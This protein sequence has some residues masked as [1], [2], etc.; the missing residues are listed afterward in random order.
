MTVSQ[1]SIAQASRKTRLLWALIAL[2]CVVTYVASIPV[3]LTRL[4][5]LCMVSI[6]PTDQLTPGEYSMLALESISLSTYA[7][8]NLVGTGVFSV[9][10]IVVG[11][12]IALRLPGERM[13]LYTSTT[14]LVFGVFATEQVDGLGWLSFPLEMWVDVGSSAAWV[15]F[16]VLLFVFPDGH[17]YPGWTRWLAVAWVLTQVPYFVGQ[18]FPAAVI[19][20]VGNWP[21]WA[22]LP[23][24]T[25]LFGAGVASQITRY[26]HSSVLQRQQTKWVMLGLA[27]AAAGVIVLS[28]LPTVL[29]IAWFE[30]GSP[31]KMVLDALVTFCLLPLPVS[32]AA[33]ILRRRLWDVD[34]YIN[35]ALVY[36]I[37]TAIIGLAYMI[38]VIVFQKMLAVLVGGEG[39]TLSTALTTLLVVALFFPLRRRLQ[40]W[41]DRRFYRRRYDAEQAVNALGAALRTEVDP[42]ALSEQVLKAVDRAMLPDSLSLWLRPQAVPVRGESQP[43]QS[44]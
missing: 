20:N 33:A 7:L 22:Q 13:A 4:S 26:R 41:I 8:Y 28:E 21:S 10:F 30:M 37:L 18:F 17:F 5:S 15:L 24:Y 2:A 1:S 35:R 40:S 14:L 42:N 9:F 36:G 29:S 44:G 43:Y 23:V 12:L 3:A 31:G 38:L 32:L 25:F 11:L 19:F 16:A 6:C 34:R 39:S 27:L